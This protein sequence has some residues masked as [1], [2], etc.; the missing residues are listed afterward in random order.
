MFKKSMAF[1]VMAILLVVLAGVGC[2]SAPASPTAAPATKAPTAAPAAPAATK[3]P[4]A[5]TAPAAAPTQAPAAA[6][7]AP[8]AAAPATDFPT[9][10]ITIYCGS[11]AGSPVDVMA[12]EMAKHMEKILGKAVVVETRSG[13]SQ[14]ELLLEIQQ[15]KPDGYSLATYTT[16]TVGALAGTL[17]AR[18]KPEDFDFLV[19]VQL[20]P[21]CLAANSDSQFQDLKGLIDYAKQNP[22][23][24][25][26]AGFG[27]GSGHHLA[28]L[29]LQQKSGAKFSWVATQGGSEAVAAALGGH[30]DVAHSN[31]SGVSEQVEAKK[32]RVLGVAASKQ[33][34][35][36]PGAKTY[37]EQGVDMT[38]A[39][40]RG[41]GAKAGLPA[42]VKAK[43]IDTVQKVMQDKDFQT[44]MKNTAQE[45]G[46]RSGDAF[47]KAVLAE[48]EMTVSTM[49]ELGLTK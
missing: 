41:I 6:T 21:Y 23:K 22:S 9:K 34:A 37:K 16:S 38:A 11:A 25:K 47:Q 19:E 12:R 48:F 49:K 44:Y 30:V 39:Q 17:K 7:K 2:G 29:E 4:A 3:A 33:I 1:V 24:V 15:G 18:M 32:M 20:D 26:V 40:W 13:G 5:A 27:T 31:P 42:P 35:I 45:A 10:A 28:L 36:L 43:L 46:E 8:A 14:A